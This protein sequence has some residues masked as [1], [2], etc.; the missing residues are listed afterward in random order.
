[1]KA[2]ITY[3]VPGEKEGEFYLGIQDCTIEFDL[4]EKFWRNLYAGIIISR[5][6]PFEKDCR[7][8]KVQDAFE[9]SDAMIEE[10]RKRDNEKKYEFPKEEGKE[11][12]SIAVN[13]TNWEWKK[14]KNK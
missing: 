7:G 6:D 5:L 2:K 11:G 14:E 12:E 8:I 13:E 9:L 10:Q 3:R 4:D 1:M